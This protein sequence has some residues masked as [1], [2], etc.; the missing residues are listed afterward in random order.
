MPGRLHCR[1]RDVRIRTNNETV[2]FAAMRDPAGDLL[3]LTVRKML[4]PDR[5]VKKTETK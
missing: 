2:W 4:D 3:E 5:R 1:R